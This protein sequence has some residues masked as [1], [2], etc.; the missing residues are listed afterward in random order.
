MDEK[1]HRGDVFC[2]DEIIFPINI[3][4]V[5][6][7]CAVAFM[8]QRKIQVCDSMRP[9]NNVQCLR[10]IKRFTEDEHMAKK[11]REL[12]DTEKWNLVD[13]EKKTPAQENGE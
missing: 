3:G 2:L 10:T 13:S 6:W 4:K 7:I 11:G 9:C 1:G 5:H 8:D 12:P